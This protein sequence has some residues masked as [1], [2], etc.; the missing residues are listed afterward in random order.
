MTWLEEYRTYAMALQLNIRSGHTDLAEYC[1]RKMKFASRRGKI[2]LK[3]KKQIEE[4][5]EKEIMQG[6]KKLKIFLA[7]QKSKLAAE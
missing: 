1:R 7:A 2:P 3:K 5:V 4:E 6:Y